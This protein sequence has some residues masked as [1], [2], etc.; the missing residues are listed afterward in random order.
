MEAKKTDGLRL[1]P[2]NWPEFQ[3]YRFRS[4]PWIKLHKKLLS[5]RAFMMLPLASKAMAP[6]LWLLASES[7]TADGE[8]D[9]STEEL[10][11]RLHLS[12][13]DIA[14]GLG[15]LIESEF[16]SVTSGSLAKQEVVKEQ[17]VKLASPQAGRQTDISKKVVDNWF[18]TEFWPAYPK[19]DGKEP[20]R[21]VFA[22]INPSMDLMGQMLRAIA[23]QSKSE[24][25]LKDKG[26]FIPLASTWLHQ[27]RWED[28]GVQL[29]Q[30]ESESPEEWSRRTAEEYA[31]ED[32]KT[33]APPAEF[34]ELAKKL[35]RKG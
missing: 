16:F 10:Q 30:G 14:S 26:Q 5:N 33:A 31:K 21:K 25:W 3:H 34:R 35:L 28:Q 1:V 11:F 23:H 20:A 32:A 15:P 6:L 8:F 24:Q 13:N 9:A 22:K 12:S 4:P 19:K 27:K 2:N 29:E 17:V 7:K 18:D